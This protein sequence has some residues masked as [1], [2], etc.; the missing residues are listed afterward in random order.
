LSPT[1]KL[2]GSRT[3]GADVAV[4][5]GVPDAVPRASPSLSSS[6][7]AE[8]ER[9][10]IETAGIEE[11]PTTAVAV[12]ND[13]A[14]ARDEAAAAEAPSSLRLS[15]GRGRFAKSEFMTLPA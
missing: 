14:R 7:P 12:A 4:S 3:E 6:L 8:L 13:V 11:S 5:L 1:S 9:A 10:G 2:S 15:P